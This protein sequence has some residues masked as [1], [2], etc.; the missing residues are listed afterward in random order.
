MRACVL[1]S[2]VVSP[3]LGDHPSFLPHCI[4]IA[5]V[6]LLYGVGRRH[7]LQATEFHCQHTQLRDTSTR[8]L[9]SRKLTS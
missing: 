7:L 9:Y 8:L 1:F 6:T 2:V 4:P 3:R 5:F